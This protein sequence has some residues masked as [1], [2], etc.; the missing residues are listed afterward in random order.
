M[1]NLVFK[2]ENKKESFIDKINLDNLLLS[3]NNP[4]YTLL[5]IIDDN[6]LDFIKTGTTQEAQIEIFNRLFYSE[7][8]LNNLVELL[9]NIKE[10]GFKNELEPIYL[11]FNKEISKFIVAEGNR[12]IMCLKMI[13]DNNFTAPS[14]E[15]YKINYPNNSID[16]EDDYH[17]EFSKV[18]KNLKK[19]NEILNLL[20]NK[21][22]SNDEEWK[23]FYK[24]IENNDFLWKTIYDK[25][26]TGERP[27]M[28]KWSRGKYFSDL[29]S[30]FSKQFLNDKK[31]LKEIST[32]I[33][34]SIDL[35][36]KDFKEAQFIYYC[37]FYGDFYSKNLKNDNFGNR[38]ILDAILKSNRISALERMHSFNKMRKIA[39]E[40]ILFLPNNKDFDD[41]YFSIK[42]N[43]SNNLIEFQDHKISKEKLLKFIF[44]KWKNNVITTRPIKREDK[45]SFISELRNLILDID[46][47]KQIPIE[48][49]NNLEIFNLSKNELKLI[50]NY[51]NQFYN[52]D[53][54]LSFEYALKIIENNETIVQNV[55]ILGFKK[56]INTP[57]Y[58]FEILRRQLE[59]NSFGTSERFLNAIFSTIRSFFEQILMWMDYLKLDNEDMKRLYIIKILKEN[60]LSKHVHEIRKKYSKES[61]EF[62]ILISKILKYGNKNKNYDKI[63]K[64]FQKIISYKIWY[65]IINENIHSSHRI[66]L[67]EIYNKSL[68]SYSEFQDLVILLMNEI[69]FKNLEEINYRIIENITKNNQHS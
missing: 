10:N 28:R 5:D 52:K 2:S 59:H 22:K 69:D 36:D 35:I 13:F 58:V 65:S 21:I 62:N 27:G 54:L 67:K 56:Y 19:I 34:R 3:K 45:N 68:I 66:Y 12:R 6:L 18:E 39:C 15:K 32:R 48:K 46:F 53:I 8:E 44:T 41:N 47:H 16:D 57:L 7:G 61:K 29:L 64:S 17:N 51:Q 30:I 1:I 55:N 38:E 9:E 37:F 20:K 60:N 4:R 42:F 43:R 50:I 24:I 23:V 40:E 14:F 26:L 63:K 25:H 11:I 31:Y 33:N 49:L